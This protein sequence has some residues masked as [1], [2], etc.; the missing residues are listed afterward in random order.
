MIKIGLIISAIGL[1]G[2]ILRDRKERLKR[3]EEKIYRES[4][5]EYLFKINKIKKVI[6]SEPEE[7]NLIFM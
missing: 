4:Y 2:H 1:L 6:E 7:N 5:K 3:I